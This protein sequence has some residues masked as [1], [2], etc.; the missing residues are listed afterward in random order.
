MHTNKLPNFNNIARND[1]FQANNQPVTSNRKKKKKEK[2]VDIICKSARIKSDLPIQL[3][4][5]T[6]L[7]NSAKSLVTIKVRGGK[8]HVEA[9][10]GDVVRSMARIDKID[11][12]KLIFKN[13]KTDRCEYVASN[14][15]STKKPAPFK[16]LSSSEGKKAMAKMGGHGVKNQGNKF[17]IS[18]KYL[19]D[20][21]KDI[22]SILTQARAIQVTQPD[23]SLCFN[24]QEVEAGSIYS[25]LGIGNN[26]TICEINGKKIK[27]INQVMDIFG[28]IR[29]LDHLDLKIKR[30]GMD[31]ILEYNLSK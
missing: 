17:K 10:E 15:K 9:R 5:S 11:R 27:S 8:N 31:S 25:T 26:D 12:L 3:V 13:L 14:E 20:K 6:V 23:G 30:N 1:P 19:N 24:I 2:R 7:Q 29:N 16:V 21:L 4:H 28:K 18:K 22:G